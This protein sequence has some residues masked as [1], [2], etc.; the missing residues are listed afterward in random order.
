MDASIICHQGRDNGPRFLAISSIC[1]LALSLFALLFG[2][3]PMLYLAAL[4]LMPVL[5]LTGVRRLRDSQLPLYFSAILAVPLLGYCSVLAHSLSPLFT[6]FWLLFAIVLTVGFALRRSPNVIEYQQGYSGPVTEARAP[7]RP[8]QRVEPS[9][10]GEVVIAPTLDFNQDMH[11]LNDNFEL[12]QVDRA[13]IEASLAQEQRKQGL[14][15]G[16]LTAM[17]TQCYHMAI[18]YRYWLFATAAAMLLL[19]SIAVV[20]H[21]WSSSETTV[22]Y[23]PEVAPVTEVMV[24]LPDGFSLVLANKQLLMRWRNIDANLGPLWSQATAIGDNTCA[25]IMFNS[26]NKYRPLQ[27]KVI[28]DH[29]VEAEFSALDSQ[30]LI[31]DMAKRNSVQLCGQQ[32]SLKGSGAA[33]TGRAEFN[34]YL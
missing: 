26:G 22:E 11:Q 10:P 8:A 33:L 19:A 4:L 14:E 23:S 34:E 31:R 13:E 24:T 1:Y 28:A 32:F 27:V 20:W 17:L 2:F 21:F 25:Y 3:T 15:Q 16:S 9:M 6:I 12:H 5:L 30:G 18:Q 29:I 7:R